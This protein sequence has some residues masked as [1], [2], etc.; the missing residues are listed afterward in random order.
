MAKNDPVERAL[1]RLGELR[2]STPAPALDE[3]RAFL[4]NRSNL[5]VAKA[6]KLCGELDARGLIPDLVAAFERLM[7]DAPRLDRRCAA[8]TEIIEALYQLDY[9][10]PAPYLRGIHHYQP[11]AS[12]GPPV[13]AAAKLRGLSAQGLLRTRNPDVMHEVMP[14]LVDREAAARIGAA[15]ALATNG[16]DAGLLLLKFKVLTGDAE[17]EVLAECFAGIL[18]DANEQSVRFV[19]QYLESEDPA[20]VEAAILALGESKNQLAFELL[21]EK[22]DRTVTGPVRKVLLT[23]LASSRLEDAISFLI[24]V[25]RDGRVKTA[26]DALE[27]LSVYKTNDRLL[28]LIRDA[29]SGRSE[30]EVRQAFECH[31]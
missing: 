3:I 14:L 9:T 25:V 18:A 4:R 26:A 8:V 20:L 6:A 13:D 1:E 17:P 23:A 19:A 29:V 12:F 2:H 24:S 5:V 31:F 11:E 16:G 22:W 7:T 28:A 30:H 27:A 15:R 10:E 21:K